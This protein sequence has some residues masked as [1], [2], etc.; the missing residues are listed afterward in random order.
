MKIAHIISYFQPE[1]GYEESSTAKYQILKGHEVKIFTSKL[2]APFSG[3]TKNQRIREDSIYEGI[4]IERL[5]SVELYTDLV[6]LLNLK[7]VIRKFSPDVI[8]IHTT[9]Q[10]TSWQGYRVATSLNIP[11][12]IDCHDFK[13][14]GSSLKPL[15]WNFKSLI[16]YCEFK[17]IRKNFI[18]K[19]LEKSNCIISVAPVCTEYLI[20][21][22]RISKIR[23][24]ELNLSIDHFKYN[25]SQKSE[26][27]YNRFN[28]G[29]DDFICLHTGINSPRKNVKAYI[30]IFSRLPF[31]YKLVLVLKGNIDEIQNEILLHNMKE[32]VRLFIDV[33]G[34][35]MSNFYKN[36]DLGIWWFNNSISFLEAIACGL[37]V[38]ISDLQLS[39][40]INKNIS[41]ILNKTQS[42]SEIIDQFLSLDLSRDNLV[43]L[44]LDA[45]EFVLN[46]LTYSNYVDK[47]DDLYKNKIL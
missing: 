19:A 1:Y 41:F 17:F 25:V 24:T 23:I 27:S 3:L 40:L 21:E 37:P 13:F 33:K 32:R 46:N 8:H 35:E 45:R 47:L 39:Y 14:P 42:D 16:K 18:A 26:F 34:E 4:I 29:K 5:S 31:S 30:R 22:F 43:K 44:S 11:F 2:T 9:C 36:A 6:L 7:S 10:F 28:F 12:V 20:D 38:C 15:S